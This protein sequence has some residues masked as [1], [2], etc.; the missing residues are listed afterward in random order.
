M[1]PLAILGTA[2]A[3]SLAIK[4]VKSVL[5][6]K[7]AAAELVEVTADAVVSSVIVGMVSEA[8]FGAAFLPT[9]IL[10]FKIFMAM[11]LVG[12]VLMC[13]F[14]LFVLSASSSRI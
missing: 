9:A 13:G 3:V 8:F 1:L 2:V 7:T 5:E 14:I 4:A 11:Y 10:S 6:V 12:W